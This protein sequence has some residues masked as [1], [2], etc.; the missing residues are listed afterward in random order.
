[1]SH[2]FALSLQPLLPSFSTALF[3]PDIEFALPPSTAAFPRAHVKGGSSTPRGW[4]IPPGGQNDGQQ[5]DA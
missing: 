5:D 2:L 4:Y 1:M 3:E